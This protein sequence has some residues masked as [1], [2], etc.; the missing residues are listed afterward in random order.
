[1][2][3]LIFSTILSETFIILERIWPDIINVKRLYV[4]YPLFL[5]NFNITWILS[6]DFREK[7]KY[8]VFAK[9][10]QWLRVVPEDR[11]TDGQTDEETEWETEMTKLIFPFPNFV[12]APKNMTTIYGKQEVFR[13]IFP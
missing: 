11:Q 10:V 2:C 12:N 6:T 8:Q 13:K 9:S 7:L 4:K 3:V 1:M 5:L